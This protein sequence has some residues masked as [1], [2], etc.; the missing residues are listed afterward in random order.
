ME[1]YREAVSVILTHRDRYLLVQTSGWPEDAWCFVQGGVEPGESAEEAARREIAEELGPV[2][3]DRSRDTGSVHECSFSAAQCAKKGYDGQRQ[4]IFAAELEDPDVID[5]SG[6][7]LGRIAWVGKGEV[8][9]RF[10][11]PEQRET[12]ARVLG[13]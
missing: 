7:E 13:I 8:L 12:Y 11:F 3:V 6:G 10:A 5:L 2:R 1:H 9:D 4:R